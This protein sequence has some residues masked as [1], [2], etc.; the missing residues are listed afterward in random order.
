M[1]RW[2]ILILVYP[3]GRHCE[4][5]THQNSWFLSNC[6]VHSKPCMQSSNIF[7]G[8]EHIWL[9]TSVS[10]LL[11]AHFTIQHKPSHLRYVVCL[12]PL[13]WILYE[14]TRPH[15]S[16]ACYPFSSRLNNMCYEPIRHFNCIFSAIILACAL[17]WSM[18][19]NS[20][21]L[22]WWWQWRLHVYRLSCKASCQKADRV[23]GSSLVALRSP[24]CSF[25]VFF[26][27]KGPSSAVLRCWFQLQW[28]SVLCLS[29][30]QL[31]SSVLVPFW[32]GVLLKWSTRSLSRYSILFSDPPWKGKAT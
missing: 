25:L 3:A 30:Q 1:Q 32:R 14:P 21:L 12:L 24:K 31:H 17:P 11:P 8:V 10:R 18:M 16:M 15:R 26:L 9:C 6:Q 13:C 20:H 23:D 5:G 4:K 28:F 29:A 7:G 27:K 22:G 19:P 2:L